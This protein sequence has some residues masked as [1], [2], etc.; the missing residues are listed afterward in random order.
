ARPIR[1]LDWL[2]YLNALAAVKLGVTLVKYL[3]QLLLN[4]RRRSTAGWVAAFHL[5]LAPF[6]FRQLLLDAGCS[7]DWSAASGGPL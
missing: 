3:P 1:W 2:A 4:A 6:S 7:D 5:C